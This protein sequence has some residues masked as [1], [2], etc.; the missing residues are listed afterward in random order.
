MIS[1]GGWARFLYRPSRV[2][3][4][5]IS[6]FKGK[7][8]DSFKLVALHLLISLYMG[9]KYVTGMPLTTRYPKANIIGELFQSPG[10]PFSSWAGKSHLEDKETLLASTVPYVLL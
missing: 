6:H 10:T 4:A 8:G 2:T 1:D 5:W 7:A 9:L 3:R